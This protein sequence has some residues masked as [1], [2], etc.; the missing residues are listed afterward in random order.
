MG[1]PPC[2]DDRWP[3]STEADV[4]AWHS[5]AALAAIVRSPRPA[6]A[7]TS[8]SRSWA[9]AGWGSSR[10]PREPGAAG[11]WRS[12]GCCAGPLERRRTSSGSGSRRWR[13]RSW[14]TPTSCRSSRSASTT[15]SPTSPCSTSRGRPWPGELADGP[16]PALEAARLLVPVC[17][18]IQYAHDHGVLHRD[19]K[20]S[21]ILIDR[22]G[23]PYVS[24]FG[25][26]KR[27]D[28]DAD[29]SRPPGRSSARPATWRPSRPG[30]GSGRGRRS[31]R[32]R[33][34][35][36]LGAILYH[37][38][39]GRPPFQAATPVETMLLVLEQDPSRPGAQPAGRAP[40]WR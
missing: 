8:S 17:R 36:S 2:R 31:G 11:S 27:I 33:D 25:L 21:N 12:S 13:R 6:S 34:V 14:P 30:L 7:I 22:E 24:D 39:T 28:V 3:P 10:G 26:A 40:T 32:P 18:A 5:G 1:Q 20:P 4:D 23:H 38:L 35:Y 19:L 16:L 15:A 37:M 29:R 9:G